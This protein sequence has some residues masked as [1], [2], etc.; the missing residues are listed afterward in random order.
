MC[1]GHP[2]GPYLV[3]GNTSLGTQ[4]PSPA[5]SHCPCPG[6]FSLGLGPQPCPAPDLHGVLPTLF[7]L[8]PSQFRWPSAP[9]RVQGVGADIS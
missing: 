1:T 9:G 7:R 5:W 6:A 4:L 2:W 8:A 3:V